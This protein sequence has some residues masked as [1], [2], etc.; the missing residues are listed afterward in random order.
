MPE[1]VASVGPRCTAARIGVDEIDLVQDRT[2][3]SIVRF[4]AERALVRA[5]IDLEVSLDMD[6]GHKCKI[7]RAHV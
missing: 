3:D 5:L 2:A 1:A 7:G 4:E 6:D